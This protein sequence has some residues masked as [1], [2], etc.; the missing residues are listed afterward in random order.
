[1]T[2]GVTTLV[3]LGNHDEWSNSTEGVIALVYLDIIVTNRVIEPVYLDKHDEQ[4]NS[5]SEVLRQNQHS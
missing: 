3:Y 4:S 2:N 5:T 1:M